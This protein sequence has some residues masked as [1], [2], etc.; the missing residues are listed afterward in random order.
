MREA[1]LCLMT[2]YIATLR[3]E[4]GAKA[5]EEAF[6]LMS[7]Q[8]RPMDKINLLSKAVLAYS[9]LHNNEKMYAS[10]EQM[11]VAIQDLI[12]ATPALK[13]AYSAL[14]MGMETQYALYYV[15]TGNPKKAWEHLQKQMNMIP[16]TPSCRT[17]YPVCKLMQNIIVPEK[18]T[19]KPWSHW[20]MPLP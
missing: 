12:T 7:P 10:L 15:R 16:L 6:H 2:S 8:D 20:I 4:D 5:L 13:N 18:N 1:C 14:Y 19:K 11:K 9:F 3:Y 17:E